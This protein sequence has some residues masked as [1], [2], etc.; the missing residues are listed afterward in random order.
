MSETVTYAKRPVIPDG[1]FVATSIRTARVRPAAATSI[2]TFTAAR[3]IL[4]RDV[5]EWTIA[6]HGAMAHARGRK[7]DT[8]GGSMSDVTLTASGAASIAATIESQRAAFD[9]SATRHAAIA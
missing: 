6:S 7:I 1:R 9:P 5:G 3:T 8:A 2:A 4:A